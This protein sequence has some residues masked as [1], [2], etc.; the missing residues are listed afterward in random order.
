[1]HPLQTSKGLLPAVEEE[2]SGLVTRAD[3]SDDEDEFLGAMLLLAPT[4]S[5]LTESERVLRLTCG[6][7]LPTTSMALVPKAS[8]GISRATLIPGT[9]A[10]FSSTTNSYHALG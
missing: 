2:M 4:H 6:V 9:A 7:A 1:M 10:L 5:S 3:E 8:K